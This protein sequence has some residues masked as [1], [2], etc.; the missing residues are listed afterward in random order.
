MKKSLFMLAVLAA[1]VFTSC[2]NEQSSLDFA[3]IQD[4]ATVQGYVFIDKGYVKENEC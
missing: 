1:A 3:A 4:T 2:E